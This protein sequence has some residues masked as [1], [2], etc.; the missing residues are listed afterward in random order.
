MDLT[1][2]GRVFEK[3]GYAVPFAHTIDAAR[4]IING[5]GLLDIGSVFTWLSP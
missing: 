5:A 4:A 2:I 3:V 1:I